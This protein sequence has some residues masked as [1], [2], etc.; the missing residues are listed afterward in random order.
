MKESLLAYSEAN[1]VTVF[2]LLFRKI[3]RRYHWNFDKDKIIFVDEEGNEFMP[4]YAYDPR[5]VKVEDTYYVIWCQDFYGASI[6]MAKQKT[7][8]HL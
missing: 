6:G 8:R 1:S 5:L 3:R 4:S 2:H 7:L